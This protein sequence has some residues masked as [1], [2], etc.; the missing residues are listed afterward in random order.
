MVRK[1]F[2]QLLLNANQLRV[3]YHDKSVDIF[4]LLDAHMK[5][6]RSSDGRC[7]ATFGWYCNKQWT[8]F[9]EGK[10]LGDH[11]ISHDCTCEREWVDRGHDCADETIDPR[12]TPGC[13]VSVGHTDEVK[14]AV[15]SPDG[16]KVA[17]GGEDCCIRLW[18]STSALEIGLLKSDHG[19]VECLAFS[20]DGSM[21]AAGR[22]SEILK[23]ACSG[24]RERKRA[25]RKFHP[26]R[27]EVWNIET[28]VLVHSQVITTSEPP[29][30]RGTDGSPR[31]V[32][33][34]SEEKLA[35]ELRGSV[36]VLNV[37]KGIVTKM[38]GCLKVLQDIA[39][40]PNEMLAAS[41]YSGTVVVWDTN[42]KTRKDLVCLA[43][44]PTR[45]FWTTA[46]D[47]VGIGSWVAGLMV[48]K[49]ENGREM[50]K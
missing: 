4:E 33:W 49:F 18:D 2:D 14:A 30:G 46:G 27:I 25:T 29:S 5:E 50:L 13:P 44:C 38:V 48:K 37:A 10:T 1:S 45:L 34:G 28:G 16:S 47:L 23:G 32:R 7:S 8:V 43:D 15:V 42:L 31:C 11:L 9:F 41:A 6:G 20:K 35:F 22:G 36:M 12:Y 19:I 26:P 40:G 39:W 3:E 17:S 21:L 24:R